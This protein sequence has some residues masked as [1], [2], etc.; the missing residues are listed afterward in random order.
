V[1]DSGGVQEEAPTFGLPI[2][3]T[4]EAT[5]RPEVVDAGFGTLVG[6][7]YHA[8]VAGVRR[9]TAGDRPQLLP[10]RNPFGR[11]DSSE[12]IAAR[13][14]IRMPGCRRSSLAAAACAAET[15]TR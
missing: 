7:N 11:G 15:M 4:R 9:L 12:Q 6:S 2:L 5:E 14:T 8:I 13:L 1:S 3:I 10:A